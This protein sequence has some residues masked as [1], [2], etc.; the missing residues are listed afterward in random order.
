[1]FIIIGYALIC[2]GIIFMLITLILAS[3]NNLRAS[4]KELSQIESSGYA[5]AYSSNNEKTENIYREGTISGKIN[6]RYK[7][8][9]KSSREILSEIESE[10]QDVVALRD[11]DYKKDILEAMKNKTTKT[12]SS[13]YEVEAKDGTDILISTE[14]SDKTGKCSKEDK[15]LV[16]SKNSPELD[17]SDST[18]VLPEGNEVSSGTDILPKSL[19]NG[20][21][22]LPQNNSGTDILQESGTDILTDNGTDVLASSGTD[23]LANSGTDTLNQDAN[24]DMLQ[25]VLGNSTDLLSSNEEGTD[26]LDFDPFT[27]GDPNDG[28]PYQ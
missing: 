23:I 9:S 27:D 4:L 6:P 17:H 16:K 25:D 24:T 15:T 20:T 3:K 8:I 13:N 18:D 12:H 22:I 2:I 21:D 7:P 19:E 14:V 28:D 5:K 10:K 1:M 26:M 11:N